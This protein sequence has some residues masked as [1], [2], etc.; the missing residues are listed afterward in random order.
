MT[1]SSRRWISST[2]RASTLLT[3][4]CSSSSTSRTTCRS[5]SQPVS[6]SP[7]TTRAHDGPELLRSRR[8]LPPRRAVAARPSHSGVQAAVADRRVCRGHPRDR[9]PGDAVEASHLRGRGHV[10]RQQ[11]ARRDPHRS[12][13]VDTAVRQPGE[14]AGPQLRDPDPEE[15]PADRRGAGNP[16][17]RKAAGAGVSVRP[18]KGTGPGAGAGPRAFPPR[19]VGPEPQ[20]HL[21]CGGNPQVERHSSE[22]SVQEPRNGRLRW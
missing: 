16:P 14:R 11:G 8:L 20:D 6:G 13:G 5:A 22:L 10:A 21:E 19:A 1:F 2:C 4:T 18:G 12:Q 17:R 7:R 15:P 3:S 9:C